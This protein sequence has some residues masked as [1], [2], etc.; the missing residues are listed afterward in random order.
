MSAICR[1]QLTHVTVLCRLAP[2]DI[3][4]LHASV[5]GRIVKVAR[6][7]DKFMG[8]QFAAVHSHADIMAENDRIV[9]EFDSREFGSV[10][11][12][13]IDH[14]NGMH[15]FDLTCACHQMAF[16]GQQLWYACCR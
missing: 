9:M 4:R 2:S 5:S 3:H 15:M 6:H 12:V 11:Q 16:A 7:G 13:R 10:V 14:A 1:C 8:S